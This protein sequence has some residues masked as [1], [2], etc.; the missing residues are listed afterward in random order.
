VAAIAATSFW[1]AKLRSIKTITPLCRL[2]ISCWAYVVS[3]ALVGPKTASM[4][5]RVPQATRASRRIIG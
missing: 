2:R 1:A 3:P 4:T 5:V